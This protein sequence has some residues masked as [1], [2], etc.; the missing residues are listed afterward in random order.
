MLCCFAPGVPNREPRR[1]SQLRNQTSPHKALEDQREKKWNQMRPFLVEGEKKDPGVSSTDNSC[2][3]FQR[4]QQ[5]TTRHEIQDVLWRH[6][7]GSK[8][9]SADA[10]L[11]TIMT[12][13]TGRNLIA[14]SC[15]AARHNH[16]IFKYEHSCDE[17]GMEHGQ[18][19]N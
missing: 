9:S 12:K 3:R 11:T 18:S 16:R 4:Q 13:K 6:F 17:L 8:W 5:H 7:Q 14:L 15:Q 10:L 19:R 2:P 1:I